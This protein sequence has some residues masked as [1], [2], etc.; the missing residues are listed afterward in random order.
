MGEWT[1]GKSI[2]RYVHTSNR[3]LT[4]RLQT[5]TALTLLYRNMSYIPFNQLPPHARLW[6]FAAD[7]ALSEAESM[8][9]TAEASAFV[10]RW[11]A[12]NQS[13]LASAD[14]RYDR[15]L[16][17]AVDEATAGASG[18]S[19]DE[20]YRRIRTL[21]E[22][23]GVNFMNN[24]MVFFRN[25]Q[26]NITASSREAFSEQASPETMVFDNSIT[27]V[28]AISNWEVPA[29]ESWHIGLIRPIQATTTK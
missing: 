20:L 18:C 23:F 22:T 17:I 15:F 19:I 24:M 16:M 9:L 21:G 3:P 13:L 11:T 1:Y 2:R 14:L 4:I 29:K 8:Q 10:D 26:G 6:V 7:R 12:H 25:A 5:T 28:Q 27:S